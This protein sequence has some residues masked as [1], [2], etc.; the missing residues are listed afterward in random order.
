MSVH[1]HATA[2]GIE[3]FASGSEAAINIVDNNVGGVIAVNADAH[4]SSATWGYAHASVVGIEQFAIASTLA[5]NSIVNAGTITVHA[6]ANA[7]N[8]K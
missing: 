7:A 8:A 2:V 5:H 3:Q 6:S 4:V 1:A